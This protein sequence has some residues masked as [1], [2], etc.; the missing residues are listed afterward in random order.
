M[1]KQKHVRF[2]PAKVDRTLVPAECQRT[3]VLASVAESSRPQYLSRLST[4]TT[5]LQTWR[6]ERDAHALTTTQDEFMCFLMSWKDQGMGDPEETRSAL[7]QLQRAHGV[8]TW[9]ASKTVVKAVAG[10]TGSKGPDKLVLESRMVR[11]YELFIMNAKIELLGPCRD[12]RLMSCEADI[13]GRKLLVWANRLMQEIGIRLCNLLDMQDHHLDPKKKELYVPR[14]KQASGGPGCLPCSPEGMKAFQV[15][16]KGNRGRYRSY[17]FPKCVQK[18]LNASLR[19]AGRAFGW[20]PGL[21]HTAYCLRH[22]GMR[23]KKQRARN[24]MDAVAEDK[25]VSVQTAAHY[26]RPNAK[27]RKVQT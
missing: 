10:A 5:F 21:V 27:R 23:Q 22:T 4:L 8:D 26:S 9:A 3:L 16:V 17:L 24:E 2:D 12:C 6:G 13:K 11:Q 25:G 15:V 18:H 20:E 7:L 1:S 19:E 14:L